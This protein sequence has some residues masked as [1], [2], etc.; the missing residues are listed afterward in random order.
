MGK[1][2]VSRILQQGQKGPGGKKQR[3][4]KEQKNEYENKD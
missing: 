3:T 2:K 4:M 1:R